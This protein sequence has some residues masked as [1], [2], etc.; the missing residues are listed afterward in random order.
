[1]PNLILPFAVSSKDRKIAFTK[2][3]EMATILHLAESERKKGEGIILKKPEEELAFIAEFCYPVWLIPWRERTLLFD[4]IGITQHTFTYEVLPDVK[5]FLTDIEGCTEGLEAY[6]A[7]LADHTHYFQSVSRVEKKTILGLITSPDVIQDLSVYLA[8]AEEVEESEIKTMRLSPV[9][10]ESSIA[11]SLNELSELRTMLEND[12][13]NLRYC[14]KLLN[15]T[16]RKHVGAIR[17]TIRETRRDFNEK[18]A[19]AK[20]LATE[21]VREI[22]ERY[23]ARITKASKKFEHQLQQLHQEKVKLEKA[24]ERAIA[25]I[26]RCKAEIEATKQRKDEA[27]Q[28]RWKQEME[29]WKR[30]AKMLRQSIEQLEK[31]IENTESEK[32]VK[33]SNLRSEFNAQVENAMKNVREFEA[34]REAQIQLNQKKIESLEES[35]STIIA[36]LDNLVKQK[37]ASLNELEKMGMQDNRRKSALVHVPLYLACFQ[38]QAKRRYVVYPPSIAGTMGVLTRFKGIFGASR[39]KSLFL[40]RSKAVASILNQLV[41]VIER[42]PVFKRDL[43]DIAVQNNIL[44]SK[45]EVKRGLEGLRNEGWIS[46]NEFQAFSTLLKKM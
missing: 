33:I 21:K 43:H 24:E 35:T 2:E 45:E 4:G 20:S 9:I 10:N 18:I 44:R 39:V 34:S 25:Q 13:E 8:E 42:D 30:E 41:T 23:D 16:T 14:M 12:I 22:Q 15:D 28:Q 7:A 19:T 31:R 32:R 1:M 17:E 3:M 46:E 5:K 29:N 36:Q 37:R 27:I 40:P 11:S 38:A 26:D 6:S